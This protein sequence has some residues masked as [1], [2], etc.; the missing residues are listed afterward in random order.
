MM[1]NQIPQ[2]PI[3]ELIPTGPATFFGLFNLALILL[4]FSY[5]VCETWRTRSVLPLV[6]LAGCAL[7]GLVE[8]IFD[9]NIHVMFAKEGQPP[10]WYFYNVGYPWYVIPGN[11]ILSAPVYWLYQQFK[12]GIS[13]RGLWGCFLLLY[14]FDVVWEIPGTVVG[15]YLYYGP[16]PFKFFG[17]PAWIGMMSGFGLPLAGFG[18]YALSNALSG[19]R[20]WLAILVLTSVVIYGSE[21]IAWP[22]WI[23]LNGGQTVGVTSVMA[24]LSL[25]FVLYGYYCMTQVYAKSRALSA[26]G[27]QTSG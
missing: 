27:R 18:A 21:L 15:S 24:L 8:P 20:L 6:F 26:T 25:A 13:T 1:I 7:G 5:I 14:L 9:G 11:G 22:M 10:N 16:H 12:R 23:T 3:A 19:T 17:F 4:S 2:P